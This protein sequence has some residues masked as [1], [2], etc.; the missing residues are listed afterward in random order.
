MEDNNTDIYTEVTEGS[1]YTHTGDTSIY[2]QTRGFP[3]NNGTQ[4][5]PQSWPP[6][7]GVNGAASNTGGLVT[8]SPGQESFHWERRR[9]R[10]EAVD[11][12][13]KVMVSATGEA[14]RLQWDRMGIYYATGDSLHGRQVYQHENW[15]QNLF[16]MYG[17]FDG[18]LLGPKSN[19]NFGGLKNGHDG[20]CVHTADS[21]QSRGW[22]YYAGPKDTRDPKEAFPHWRHDDGSLTVRCVPKSVQID[23]RKIP[24]PDRAPLLRKI[25]SKTKLLLRRANGRRPVPGPINMEV[26]LVSARCSSDCHTTSISLTLANGQADILLVAAQDT[27]DIS[28]YCF[29]CHSYWAG[30]LQTG[31][32]SSYKTNVPG[33]IFKLYVI[34]VGYTDYISLTVKVDSPNV[35][36]TKS[37][38]LKL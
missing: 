35:L 30:R 13:K 11:C 31:Q 32:T 34:I 19:E 25:Y 20:M 6:G 5:N 16:Y 26:W 10:R 22:G 29:S 12:C 2:T 21:T 3:Y 28:N 37:E 33:P 4:S 18:W 9:R 27:L 8:W 15:T 23:S 7:A 36:E 17:E 24:D 1:G 38:V 14:A